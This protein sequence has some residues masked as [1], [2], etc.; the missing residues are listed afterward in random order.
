MIKHSEKSIEPRQFSVARS[1]VAILKAVLSSYIF[2]IVAF[3]VL[4]L[5]Y[6]YSNMSEGMLKNVTNALSV[7]SLVIAGFLSSRTISSFG[8]LHGA[9]AGLISTLIRILMGL[10]VFKSYVHSDGVFKVLLIGILCAMVG[11]VLGVN[12]GKDKPRTSTK[13]KRK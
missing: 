11:G 10:V 13:K 9:L 12:L 6:T 7:I 5:V 2:L 8:W 1:A 4:A 3:T